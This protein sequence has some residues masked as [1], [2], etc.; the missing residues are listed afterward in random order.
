MYKG[1]SAREKLLLKNQS[2][3]KSHK[4]D[5]RTETV[6]ALCSEASPQIQQSLRPPDTTRQ[7]QLIHSLVRVAL[8]VM[9]LTAHFLGFVARYD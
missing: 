8:Y 6:K 2:S 5:I 9:T 3:R 7:R 1:F 4:I